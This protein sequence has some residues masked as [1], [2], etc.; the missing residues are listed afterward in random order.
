MPARIPLSTY[1]LQLQGAFTFDQAAEQ[2]DYLQRLGIGDC[3]LSPVLRAR[4]GSLLGYDV[5]E[6]SR[7][8][9]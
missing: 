6:H 4:P 8:N 9:P 7:N 1:R 2:L 5:I 3:Y